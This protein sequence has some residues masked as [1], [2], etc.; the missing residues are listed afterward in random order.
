MD[1]IL[2]STEH[3]LREQFG[4]SISD[5]GVHVLDPF[6]GT[7]IFLVRLLQSELLRDAD[8]HRKFREEFHA[9]EIVLLAY[10]I[11]A[12]HI[13]EAF[14]GRLKEITEYEPFSGIVLTDTFNLH[15]E[16]SGFPNTWLPGNS[17]RAE[18]QQELPIQVIL[19]NPP[20]STGQRSSADNNPNVEYPEIENRISETYAASTTVRNKNSLYDTYK[21]AIRWASDRIGNRG[22]IAFVT[23]GSWIDGNA[24][25]GVRA[26]L[27]E[28]FS[29]IY[30]LNLKGNQRTQGERSRQ[31]G[32]KV[33]GS[34]S[35]A[36]VAI[37][38]LVRS[39]PPPPPP[40]NCH[41]FYREVGN[42][43]NREDKL[44]LL[45]DAKSVA[46]FDDWKIVT[47]NVHHDWI[48]QRSEAFQALYPIGS[49]MTKSGK[50]DDAIFKLYSRG[51]A[52]GRDEY[53]Y[54]Y[55]LD[56]CLETSRKMVNDYMGALR[57]LT[58]NKDHSLD[59]GNVIAR[60]S[61]NVRWERELK[62]NVQRSKI[63]TYS[64]N[65]VR[66][67]Q[68]R[69][70]VKQHCYADYLFASMKYQQDKIFP[71]PV[72][73]NRAICV[74]GIGSSTP[75]SALIVN[76]MPDLGLNS[77]TQ[78]FP[79]YIFE[80][81]DDTQPNLFKSTTELVRL[82]N[83][84]DT[85][86]RSFRIHYSN[87]SI[88]KD[89]IFDYVYGVLHAPLYR[90]LFA[91][92]LTKELPRI[93]FATDF[94]RFA[95]AGNKLAAL[96]LDYETC[97]EFPLSIESL[98]SEIVLRPSHHRIGKR[99]MRYANEEKTAL[100]INEFV[101]I[102]GIPREAHRYIVNGRTPLDWLI[103]RYYIKRHKHSGIVD[104]PNQWF[105]NPEDLISAIRR[106]V[107]VSVES[108]RI[109]DGLPVLFDDETIRQL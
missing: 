26:C 81:L 103:D 36:P 86:L 79:R 60:Y 77:A 70:F 102:S 76:S 105:K 56:T 28:E 22:I 106:I 20:W 32:G 63:A 53:I 46:G 51:Y 74:P 48:S 99:K 64:P 71:S 62:N 41:I 39:S 85:A 42:Y 80:K 29:S 24:D 21:M 40:D 83:I 45:S 78:C 91:N 2:A 82:D 101:R 108:M 84:S 54:N 87:N 5:E 31:E 11:A 16:R 38:L 59:F 34:G 94:I 10:Y 33:F 55:S 104:D 6:T 57:E 58:E 47:P 8:L 98:Q 107:Y 68:Y 4:R 1:F 35:R 75:F 15:T 19:G 89:G 109:I 72:S 23:N 69:P 96:H 88:S 27:A 92:D 43:L 90:E 67:T 14:H 18:R 7:G 12:I 49:Q 44:K 30:V 97:G 25:S 65:K 66:I 100:N 52:T 9:N 95:D 73:E 61:S 13:E 3:I 37:T 93:P 17:A 50:A